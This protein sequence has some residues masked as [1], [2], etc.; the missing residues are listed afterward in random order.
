[1]F[2]VDQRDG[3][4][5]YLTKKSRTN[6]KIY[7]KMAYKYESFELRTRQHK[8]STS[9]GNLLTQNLT[10]LKYE[11]KILQSHKIYTI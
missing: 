9:R 6:N 2:K 3:Q 10:N 4:I 5:R 1:M 11:F 8:F 7:G